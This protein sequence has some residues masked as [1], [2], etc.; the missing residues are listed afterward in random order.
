MYS[1]G[2][3]SLVFIEKTALCNSCMHLICCT[4]LCMWL[5]KKRS[6][7]C[8]SN[9]QCVFQNINICLNDMIVKPYTK[10]HVWDVY[11]WFQLFWFVCKLISGNLGTS[12]KSKKVISKLTEK[13]VGCFFSTS[14][15]GSL[16]VSSVIYILFQTPNVLLACTGNSTD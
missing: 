7:F 15:Y 5:K 2:I 6:P 3:V 13:V 16:W 12:L 9:T 4:I 11:G 8:T 10:E 14:T 1:N